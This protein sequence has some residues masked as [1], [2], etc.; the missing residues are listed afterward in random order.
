MYIFVF[1]S[2][3]GKPIET[4]LV[5]LGRGLTLLGRKATAFQ[6]VDIRLAFLMLRS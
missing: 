3:Y 4:C 5:H 1:N 2:K 6:A